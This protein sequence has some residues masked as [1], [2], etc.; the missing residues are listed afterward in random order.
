MNEEYNKTI[1]EDIEHYIEEE[2]FKT[3]L[4][5][6]YNINMEI[7][8]TEEAKAKLEY[9]KTIKTQELLDSEEYSKYKPQERKSRVKNEILCLYYEKEQNIETKLLQ[10]KAMKSTYSKIFKILTKS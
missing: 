9:E 10:L 5:K 2:E 1:T 4:H 7:A 8:A 3:L 6:H